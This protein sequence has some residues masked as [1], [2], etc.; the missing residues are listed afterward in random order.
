MTSAAGLGVL[1]RK[2]T[3]STYFESSAGLK[4]GAAVNLQ[5]V[6]VGTVKS[7]TVTTAP[8]R[9]LTPVKVV[10]KLNEKFATSLKKDSK[11]SLTTVGV[12]GD[13]VVDINS[14]FATGPL[15]QDGDELKT[16]ETPSLFDVVKESQGAIENV[17]ILISK[18]NALVDNLQSGKDSFGQLLTNPQIY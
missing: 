6:T 17:N 2:L 9:K 18:M 3:I 13:T 12:L 8:D 14:Q 10:M 1:S 4:E 11:A 5:G 16:L 7:V 15:L